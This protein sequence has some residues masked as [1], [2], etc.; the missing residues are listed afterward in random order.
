MKN[1]FL[2]KKLAKVIFAIC[3][4]VLAFAFWFIITY[5]NLGYMSSGY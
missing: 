5:N 2:E 1:I 3:C 4:G